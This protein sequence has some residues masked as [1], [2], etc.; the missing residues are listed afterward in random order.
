VVTDPTGRQATAS[1]TIAVAAGTAVPDETA[2]RTPPVA[3]AIKLDPGARTTCGGSIIPIH[4][5]GERHILLDAAPSFDPD[6]ESCGPQ[7]LDYE[8]T[9]LATPRSGGQSTLQST[10][11]RT[12]VLQVTADGS[13]QVRLVVTDATGLSSDETVCWVYAGDTG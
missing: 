8:W 3:A 4:L 1:G 2:C 13:Y 11:G 6:P 9:L 7:T 10:N 5:R 12:T